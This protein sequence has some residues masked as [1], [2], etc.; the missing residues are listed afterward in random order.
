MSRTGPMIATTLPK[1]FSAM[2]S[3][4]FRVSGFWF[5]VSG[6][7]AEPETSNETPETFL[8]ERRRSRDDLDQFLRDAR[9]ARPV[10]GERQLVDHLAR[11]LRGGVHRGHPRAHLGGG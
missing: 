6:G 4:A 10:V 3:S 5:L 8:F 7:G 2:T 11:V 9:L 1:F